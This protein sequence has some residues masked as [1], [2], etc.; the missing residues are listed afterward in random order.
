MSDIDIK[1]TFS[2]EEKRRLERIEK[3]DANS[4]RKKVIFGLVAAVLIIFFVAG[5]IFGGFYILSYEGTAELPQKEAV[6]N[7]FPE[8]EDEIIAEVISLIDANK[9]Y[10]STKLDVS[11]DVIIDRQS[12]TVTGEKADGIRVAADYIIDSV[13]SVI[14]S[15]YD[16][17]RYSGN[18]SE[19]FSDKLFPMVFTSD[20]AVITSY[21]EDGNDNDLKYVFDFE[22]CKFEDI[23]ENA[24][25]DV[26]GLSSAEKCLSELCEKLSTVAD[27]SDIEIIYEDF[28]VT[29][30]CDRLAEKLTS[31]KQTRKCKVR[32]PLT[33]IG[34]YAE[35]GSAVISFDMELNKSFS[36]IG[37][38]FFFTQDVFFIEK[39]SSDEVK[40]KV[41]NVSNLNDAEITYISSDENVLFIDED[42]FYK[43]INTSSEPV[44]VKGIC[45]YNGVIYEDSCI[46]YVRTPVESV[47]LKEKEISIEVG[48]KISVTPVIKPKNAELTAVYWFSEDEAIA[49]VGYEDGEITAIKAGETKIYCV[50]LDGNFKAS[51]T[52][53]VSEK[54]GN[55]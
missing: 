46:F 26:F 54:G 41:I 14:S 30:G 36:F 7:D 37:V 32:L 44:V 48:E 52:V 34:E 25:Y 40:S 2:D 45:K 5:T 38:D 35:F 17:E 51:C 9:Q 3:I 47:K 20:D 6:Y 13:I 42:N 11:F 22:G 10:G 43:G 29:A 49:T 21:T 24:V 12:L 39:G 53:K 4:K 1:S 16:E 19:D 18:Y 28:T 27:Y 50:T 8:D 55:K 15:C 23:E 31:L 33:F